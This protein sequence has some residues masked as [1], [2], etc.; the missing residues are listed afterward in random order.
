MIDNSGYK[1]SAIKSKGLAKRVLLTLTGY[2]KVEVEGD[3]PVLEELE[4]CEL[5]SGDWLMKQGDP[6]DALYFLVRGRLQAWAREEGHDRGRFLNEIVPGDSVGELSL[7]TGAPR[8]V[9]IQAIRDSLLIR[10]DQEAFGRLSLEHPA[11]VMHLATNVAKLLQSNR[12]G[13]KSSTR[14]LNSITILPL[15]SS[16]RLEDFCHALT[17]ELEREGSTLSLAAD[18]LGKKG[19]PVDSLQPGQ[20]IPESLKNWLQDQENE[21]RFLVYRCTPG[22]S[23]WSHF[24]LR[25]SD[26]VLMV[27]DASLDPAPRR[28]ELELLETSGTAIARQLLVLLQPPSSEP[29]RG[30]DLW[31]KDRRIDFH[32]HVRKDQPD[33]L[34]RVT[35]I[36]SGNALGLVLA[37]GAARGFAHLG[38]RRAMH[39]L[40]LPIDWIGGTSIGAIMGAAIA[41]PVTDDE[42][43]ELCRK[44]F[45]DG[46]PFSD[47][48]IPMMSLIRGRR[49]D[50]MLRLH[51]DYQIEDLPIPFYC[52]SCNL[53]TGSTNLHD[54]GDL[55]SALRASAALPGIIP[56]AVVNHRLTIDGSVVNNLPVDVMRQKPVS[57]IIAVDLG[58]AEL[59]T[60][61]FEAVP[62]PWAIFRGRY[63]PFARRYR[64]PSLSNIM[65]KATLLG[66]FDRVREQGQLADILLNPPVRKF[67]MTEV[68]SF[69][70]IVQAGYDHAKTEL[71][72]W[73][74]RVENESSGK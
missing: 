46:K 40:G 19:A 44:S 68:K 32:V 15:D 56:P 49:M 72:A 24:A 5:A 55:P 74:E 23:D 39:E 38:V 50:K 8:A 12:H 66:T 29:I 64:V 42:A 61:E 28:W 22:S 7:F 35:R 2:F 71:A 63:L 59:L 3:D 14:N 47:F 17:L 18:G 1:V 16:A 62:S 9:G 48:T 65:L 10:L 67:G 33:D 27:G 54:S 4:V 45:I 37:G 36:V 6:G 69:E 20:P 13:A 31:L 60:V 26:M 11:L 30:T 51:L 34:S 53:D 25:H 43:L 21:H 73:M 57:R 41:A 52:I 58:S 70:K